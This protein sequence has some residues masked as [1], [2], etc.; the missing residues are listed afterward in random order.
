MLVSNMTS[1]RFK[2]RKIIVYIV[3]VLFT[4]LRYQN[5]AVHVKTLTGLIKNIDIHDTL[6]NLRTG[7]GPCYIIKAPPA[8]APSLLLLIVA[9]VEAALRRLFWAFHREL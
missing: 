1:L 2:S 7:S 6:A 4:W 8:A 9:S 5:I 3:K